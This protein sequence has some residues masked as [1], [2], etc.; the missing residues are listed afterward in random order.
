MGARGR[1][2][3][4]TKENDTKENQPGGRRPKKRTQTSGPEKRPRAP[5]P[6]GDQHLTIR[7]HTSAPEKCPR[8]RSAQC[9]FKMQCVYIFRAVFIR[10]PPDA[11]GRILTAEHG[12]L[13]RE[14][15]A[16]HPNRPEPPRTDLGT[17]ARPRKSVRTKR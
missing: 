15:G 3:G 14:R 1:F 12:T 7:S 13:E 8:P 10:S 6:T 17:D 11:A 5:T 2:R 9:V 4:P 16:A